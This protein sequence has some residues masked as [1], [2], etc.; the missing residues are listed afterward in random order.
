MRKVSQITNLPGELATRDGR[1]CAR[2]R[3]ETAEISREYLVWLWYLNYG[4]FYTLLVW[5]VS[6]LIAVRFGIGD[7]D[8]WRRRS[9]TPPRSLHSRAE[10][11]ARD[12]RPS[13]VGLNSRYPFKERRSMADAMTR[14]VVDNGGKKRGRR[15]EATINCAPSSIRIFSSPRRSIYLIKLKQI[16]FQTCLVF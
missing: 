5:H 15:E 12:R 10:W 4:H 13:F 2:P 1:T 3:C 8:T 9:F 6:R 16:I 11:V 7:T 14:H